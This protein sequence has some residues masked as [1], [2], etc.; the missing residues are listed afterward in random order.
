MDF[1]SRAP[2]ARIRCRCRT[3][4]RNPAELALLEAWMRSYRPETLFD[5]RG[6]LIER[7]GG[8][9]AARR[10]PHGRE[11]AR[12][13]RTHARR[14]RPSGLSRSMPSTSP[15]PA[16]V[17][18]E[19]TRQLGEMLR[20]VFARNAANFRLFCPDETNSN[21]LS[22]CL[23]GREPLPRRATPLDRRPRHPRRTRD[24]SAERASVRRM[25]RGLPAH[26]PPRNVR[27]LRIVRDGVRRR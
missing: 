12:E 2:S 14:A 27:D 22:T 7:A 26:R 13:W 1:R 23:R 20:D 8:A 3:R 11:P 24:G 19:S 5:E 21:R 15:S 18:R 6:A 10:S 9:R 4:G 17:Q 25:A 16:V